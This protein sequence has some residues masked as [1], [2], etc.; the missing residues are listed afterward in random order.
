MFDLSPKSNGTARVSKRI[1]DRL[2]FRAFFGSPRSNIRLLT[3][4]APRRCGIA[5]QMPNRVC[6][7]KRQKRPFSYHP[8]CGGNLL[9]KWTPQS[10]EM[11][12]KAAKD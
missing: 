9:K 7:A 5:M 2:T 3:R 10:P 12:K 11:Q 1:C 6:G 4:A 8:I